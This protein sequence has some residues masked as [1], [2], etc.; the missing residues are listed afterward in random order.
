M[1]EFF[2]MEKNLENLRPV[3]GNYLKSCGVPSS[4]SNNLETLLQLYTKYMNDHAKHDDRVKLNVLE[5]ILYQTGNIIRLLIT[6]KAT[7]EAM[8]RENHNEN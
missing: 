1:R 4:I 7:E 8:P 2:G 3:Y 5:Y 6:L